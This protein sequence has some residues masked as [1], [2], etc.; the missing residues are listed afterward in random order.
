MG[1]ITFVQCQNLK[2]FLR[3]IVQIPL[4]WTYALSAHHKFYRIRS[5]FFLVL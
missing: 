2:C 5:E 1:N 3:S 4:K